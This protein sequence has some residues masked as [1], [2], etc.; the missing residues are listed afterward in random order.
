M[1]IT[2]SLYL[3]IFVLDTGCISGEQKR[4]HFWTSDTLILN[5]VVGINVCC[6][7]LSRIKVVLCSSQVCANCVFWLLLL[8]L[9][10][11]CRGKAEGC[12]PHLPAG[13]RETC[14]M[15]TQH[16][17]PLAWL[18]GWQPLPWTWTAS[19]SW[20][21]LSVAGANAC[22]KHVW[23]L[24]FVVSRELLDQIGW[25]LCLDYGTI[26]SAM[27]LF[28]MLVVSS[29]ANHKTL[30][31]SLFPFVYNQYVSLCKV[32]TNKLFQLFFPFLLYS[33]N[34]FHTQP[35]SSSTTSRARTSPVARP[36][37]PVPDRSTYCQLLGGGH[38]SPTSPKVQ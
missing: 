8:L 24:W 3:I 26:D 12:S 4:S 9:L 2:R 11:E 28:N 25:N 10:A 32:T 17:K 14:Q 36:V 38:Y 27:L 7:L 15:C 30:Y 22:F 18:R 33:S 21:G 34:Q 6:L 31:L 5:D 37:L 20:T 13:F 1:V 16:S 35:G 29:L 23:S 19:E